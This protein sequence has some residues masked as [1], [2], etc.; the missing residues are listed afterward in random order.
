MEKKSIKTYPWR[1][2][3]LDLADKE[4]KTI[5]VTVFHMF[6]RSVET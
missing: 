6:K 2:K 3:L 5:T 1:E 4:I